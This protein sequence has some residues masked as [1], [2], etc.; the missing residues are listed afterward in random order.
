[1]VVERIG[2]GAG[3]VK[4]LL[5][6]DYVKYG[7]WQQ[8]STWVWWTRRRGKNG[9]LVNVFGIFHVIERWSRVRGAVKTVVLYSFLGHLTEAVKVHL[10]HATCY[11]STIRWESP[12]VDVIFDLSFELNSRRVSFLEDSISLVIELL[13]CDY[14]KRWRIYLFGRNL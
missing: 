3:V 2:F 4:W 8:R 13:L 14:L 7:A 11:Q 12:D 9:R 10:K 5:S 6:A 1:M